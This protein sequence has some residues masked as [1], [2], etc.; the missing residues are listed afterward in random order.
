MLCTGIHYATGHLFDM[1]AI[2]KA[3]HSKVRTAQGCDLCTPTVVCM[4]DL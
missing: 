3:A 2:T 1:P 4:V